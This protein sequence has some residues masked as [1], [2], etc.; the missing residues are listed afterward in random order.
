MKWKWLFLGINVFSAFAC[1]SLGEKCFVPGMDSSQKIGN[2][3][4]A[5][6]DKPPLH[7]AV[8]KN[9]MNALKEL[10]DSGYDVNT[11]DENGYTPLHVAVH[12]DNVPMVSFLLQYGA[13]VTR[14]AKNGFQPIYYA[15]GT[16]D[17]VLLSILLNS[18]SNTDAN[19]ICRL[20]FLGESEQ[21]LA[22]FSNGQM[23]TSS[24]GWSPLHWG[25]AGGHRTSLEILVS[26]GLDVNCRD[27]PLKETP[28]HVAT[29]YKQSD[30]VDFLLQA[31][32]SV[33]IADG[34]GNLPLHIVSCWGP[35]DIAKILLP[36]YSDI[37]CKNSIL[38]MTPL[39]C[40][41]FFDNLDMVKLLVRAGANTTAMDKKGRT[42]MEL[43]HNEQVKH[44][45]SELTGSAPK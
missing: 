45:L 5:R 36:C 23:P 16:G 1:A 17:S 11:P 2:K 19:S 43:S 31:N 14:R 4:F 6:T 29:R 32:A 44:F 41:A 42:P 35:T 24:L 33:M 34:H 15:T 27:S 7:V 40:A 12:V 10:L 30:A 38:G 37:E 25:A 18:S 9:D 13:D 3:C 26:H 39:H 20:A 28:L 21:L 8:E 22:A